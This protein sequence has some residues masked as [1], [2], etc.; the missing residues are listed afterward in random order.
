M[1]RYNNLPEESIMQ[2]I[3]K[4]GLKGRKTA[5]R[6]NKRVA[7]NQVEEQR[8]EYSAQCGPS[9]G[10]PLRASGIYLKD[11]T[12]MGRTSCLH[13]HRYIYTHMYI[14]THTIVASVCKFF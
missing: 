9:G 1:H 4:S 8:V 10:Q 6:R 2:Y 3:K 11:C 12:E 14:H 5:N 13:T 7:F